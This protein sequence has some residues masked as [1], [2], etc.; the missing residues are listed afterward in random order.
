M[1][2]DAKEALCNKLLTKIN[3]LKD[4]QRAIEERITDL[5]DVYLDV[6]NGWIEPDSD[7]EGDDE[8]E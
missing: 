1:A 7:T 4:K 5:Q 6:V 3:R 8:D 2:S